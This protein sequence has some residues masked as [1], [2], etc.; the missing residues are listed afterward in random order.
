VQPAP[1][2][3]PDLLPIKHPYATAF[4][5]YQ[6]PNAK[7][8]DFDCDPERAFDD[9]DKA[10]VTRTGTKYGRYYAS[11]FQL[12]PPQGRGNTVTMLWAKEG[13]YWK[14]TAWDIEPEDAQPEAVPDT[15]VRAKAPAPE[16]QTKA[17]AE[18]L[19]STEQFLH[20]WLVVD[21]FPAAA[22]YFSPKSS[23]CANAFLLPGEQEPRTSEQSVA[24]MR[25][26]LREVGK[27][28]GRV[29][30]L[31]EAIEPVEPEHDDL[32]SVSHPEADAYT[33][34]AVPEYLASSFTCQK[35]ASSSEPLHDSQAKNY[36]KYYAM[37]FALRTPGDN[38]ASLSFL[39]SKDDGKW[40]I[41]S[42]SLMAP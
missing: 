8:A 35:Q 33:L 2:V 37:L 29:Q 39:W 26:A 11:V 18:L 30:H 13:N 10:R 3:D 38:P 34:V 20:S 42:Y 7:A 1:I 12:K 5:L 4:G 27:D 31:S 6:V 14:A 24:V 17:D 28:V 9:Y 22:Q 16:A 23:D 36:G 40:K 15:R 25:A 32:K 19:R 21:N 41:L